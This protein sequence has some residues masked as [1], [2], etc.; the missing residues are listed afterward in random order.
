ME[1]Q[2]FL[3]LLQGV[4]TLFESQVSKDK[5]KIP[6]ALEQIIAAGL[7]A[8]QQETGQPLDVT[9]IQPFTPIS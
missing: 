9:K 8:Y 5:A 4:T 3:A 6:V 7:A 1:L 2:I